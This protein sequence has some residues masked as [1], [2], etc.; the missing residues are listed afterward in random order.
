GEDDEPGQRPAAEDREP[1]PPASVEVYGCDQ[2]PGPL[3]PVAGRP[4]RDLLGRELLRRGLLRWERLVSRRVRVRA[5]R[6]TVGLGQLPLL[7]E[8][9]ELARRAECPRRR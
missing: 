1:A 4:G 2:G 7:P 3:Q 6:R 8:P 9:R 5:R